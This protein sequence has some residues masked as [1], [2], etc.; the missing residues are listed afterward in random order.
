M[1]KTLYILRDIGKCKI[2]CIKHVLE[3]ELYPSHVAYMFVFYSGAYFLSPRLSWLFI[4]VGLQIRGHSRCVQFKAPS[5]L[6]A[7]VLAKSM[8][9]L[10]V[11]LISLVRQPNLHAVLVAQLPHLLLLS[12]RHRSTSCHCK[13][14]GRLQHHSRLHELVPQLGLSAL[15][16]HETAQ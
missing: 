6:R 9:Q 7:P 11:S 16:R 1:S 14:C 10:S 2:R 8:Q 15:E 3:H 12:S 13:D 4:D 5:S